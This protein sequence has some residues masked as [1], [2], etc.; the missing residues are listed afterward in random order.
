MAF[1]CTF[2]TESMQLSSQ[3]N[4][5]SHMPI[6]QWYHVQLLDFPTSPHRYLSPVAPFEELLPSPKQRYDIWMVPKGLEQTFTF[7]V[8]IYFYS[9]SSVHLFIYYF[10]CKSP[11]LLFEAIL[12]GKGLQLML[13]YI[14]SQFLHNYEQN[15]HLTSE[16]QKSSKINSSKIVFK[17]KKFNNR[18]V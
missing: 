3:F 11:N 7:Y 14:V 5:I 1:F 18:I 8:A 16:F 4:S 17:K 2:C 12:S 13:L 6:K 15:S 10:C 9:E